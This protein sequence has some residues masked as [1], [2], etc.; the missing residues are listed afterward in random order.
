[1]NRLLRG[2]LIP[3]F[4]LAV[5]ELTSRFGLMTYESLS[6]PTAIA[7][8]GWTALLDGSILFDTWLTIESAL[9]GLALGAVV[10]ILLGSILG[11]STLFARMAGPTFNG[12]RAIPSVALMPLGLLMFGWGLSMEVSVVAYACCWPILIATWAAVRGVEPRLLEVADALEMSFGERLRKI[13]LPAAFAR[14]NVGVRIALGVALV[15]AVTI[16]IAVNPRGLGYALV[17]AQQSLRPD[18]MF[19][20]ILWLALIG[21]LLNAAMRALEGPRTAPRSAS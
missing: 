13:V 21:F 12:L 5:W 10:G 9:L 14:I 2:A 4:I 7:R 3:V 18:L 16:E 6:Y 15:V 20:Q 19:A 17:L 8:A 1:M 11:V